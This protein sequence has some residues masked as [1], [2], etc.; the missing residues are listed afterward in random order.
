MVVNMIPLHHQPGA[1]AGL[2]ARTGST[3]CVGSLE[4]SSSSRWNAR[5]CLLA[6]R[7]TVATARESLPPLVALLCSALTGDASRPETPSAPMRAYSGPRVWRRAQ[8]WVRTLKPCRSG[9][10]PF[11]VSRDLGQ[12]RRPRDEDPYPPGP[13]QQAV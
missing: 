3:S 5:W 10:W 1:D 4:V 13:T 12:F 9:T 7:G 6:L 11:C 2:V 8:C